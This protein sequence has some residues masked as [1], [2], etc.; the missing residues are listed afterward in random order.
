MT[1]PTGP[2]AEAPAPARTL[3]WLLEHL[4]AVTY[5]DPGCREAASQAG[6]RG[7]WMG[8]FGCR[9]APMGA[10]GPGLVEAAFFNFS[11]AMVRR[12]IP[13]AWGFCAPAALVEV[14][15]RAAAAALRRLVP[16]VEAVADAARSLLDA[17]VRDAPGSGRPLFCANRDLPAAG[18][19]VERL[20]QAAT[21]LREH[22][23]D[24]HVAALTAAGLSG[25]EPH[26][27][28]AGA[29][30][31]KAE[32][33]RESRGWSPE[34]WADAAHRLRRRGLLDDSGARTD[35]GHALLAEVE[36]VTDTLAAAAYDGIGVAGVAELTALLAEPSRA[37]SASGAVPYP[38]PIGLPPLG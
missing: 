8:Y 3:W 4:H 18:D 30:P 21:T 35:E 2:G 7:F 11:P 24:G 33:I 6:L 38:N 5:F 15:R 28:A 20:W 34:A 12:A 31:A 36:R 17:A 10:V 27:L 16:G 29:E 37:V 1:T 13:D 23:G 14:R 19:A 25:C 22:R 26:L 9:A 32:V